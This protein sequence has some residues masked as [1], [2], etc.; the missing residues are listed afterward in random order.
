MQIIFILDWSSICIEKFLTKLKFLAFIEAFFD[1]MYKC[2]CNNHVNNPWYMMHHITH[3][4]TLHPTSHTLCVLS[5]IR[6]SLTL[7]TPRSTIV[8]LK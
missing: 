8:L 2:K 5:Y 4:V 1:V 6:H 7:Y 3:P